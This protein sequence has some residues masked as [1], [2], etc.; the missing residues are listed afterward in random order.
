MMQENI[1]EKCIFSLVDEYNDEDRHIFFNYL[2]NVRFSCLEPYGK[3]SKNCARGVMKQ[4]KINTTAI[5]ACI[6]RNMPK[7]TATTHVSILLAED[8]EEAND[9]GVALTPALFIN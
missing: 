2:Y 7:Q 6:G 1:R 9:F 8:R 3:I 5:E 4:L